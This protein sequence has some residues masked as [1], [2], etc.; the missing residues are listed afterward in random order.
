LRAKIPRDLET[1]CLKCLRK[2]PARRYPSAEEL[3]N[4]LRRFQAGE[5]VQARPT[6]RLERALKWV[7]RRPALAV[8]LGVT[9]LA[10]VALGGLA[11]S[12]A[13]ARS[14]A[15]RKEQEA[16]QEA[17]KAKKARDFLVSIFKLSD[18]KG[19]GGTLTARQILDHADRRLAVEFA[20][21]P[22]LRADLERAIE[23][24]YAALGTSGPQAMILEARGTV[25]LESVREPKRQAVPQTLLYRDD[26]LLVAADAD[27]RLVFLQDF[28]QERVQPGKEVSI[29]RKG[30]QPGEAISE[31]HDGLLMTFVRLPK[32]TFYMGWN[33]KPGSARKT[34]I[35]EDFEIAV[36]T[37]TQGQWQA[38]MGAN[39]SAFS[40]S[41]NGQNAV[42]EISDDELKLFPVENVS[43]HDTQ[44]FIK[45]L[46]EKE[47]GRGYWYRLP[48]EAEWEYA[49]RGG[50]T[51]E[52]EC[53]YHFYFAKPTNDLS[54]EQANF[55]GNVPSGNAPK[56]KALQRTTR[57]GAYPPNKLG[58]RDMHGNVWQWCGDLDP[59]LRGGSL[60]VCRGGSWYCGGDQC[61]AADSEGIAPSHWSNGHGFRLARVPVR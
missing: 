60:R 33:G 4:D 18:R 37:V 43:W 3:A 38:L 45:R 52:A 8:L 47:R 7:K 44:E 29:G 16:R 10:L 56:G 48:S 35:K 1:I 13:V 26:R 57:V 12:L 31:R 41:G 21:Q 27:V 11:G 61:R 17:D 5:P 39:P 2:E 23:E 9:L 53:S 50:A 32:G 19:E 14:E 55:L 40:R 24:V 25:R 15:E 20:E 46:N 28:H 49:C 42:R 54:A 59:F 34:E 51:S 58:L 30:C 22:E 36:H 6:G